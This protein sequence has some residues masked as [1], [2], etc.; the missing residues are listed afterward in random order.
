MRKILAA[1]VIASFAVAGLGVAPA[2]SA[3]KITITASPS[4][5]KF[6]TVGSKVVAAPAKISPKPSKFTLEWLYN[7]KPIAKATA[8]SYKIPA[9]Q[10]TGTLQLRE[11]AIVGTAKKVLVSNT[12]KIGELF[13]VANPQISYTDGTNT[14]LAITAAQVLPAPESIKYTFARDTETLYNPDNA[15]THTL[16]LADAGTQIAASAKIKAPAGYADIVLKSPALSIASTQRVYSQVWSDEFN[17]APAATANAANWSGEDGDGV[18]Y[19]NRGWGNSEREWYNF[20]NSTTD[21]N[22]ILNLTATSVNAANTHCY[23]GPCEFLSSKLVTKGKVGFTYGRLEARI[24]AAPGQGTWN[25]FWTL[26]TD[27]DTVYWPMCG[28]IDAMEILG[29]T[30]NHL[31]GYLHGPISNGLGRGNTKDFN[32]AL[33]DDFH[34]YTID[35]LPDQVT[36]YVDG[37]KY[38]SVSKTDRDWVFNHE[39]YAILNLAMGGNLGGTIDPALTS[40]T[41]QVDYVR[42]STINGVGTLHLYPQG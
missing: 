42:Y 15:M 38:G 9:N 24:K 31:L 36:W 34:T 6:A 35:W 19:G 16:S 10:P 23:Y 12:I 29:S 39:F 3:V 17:G 8:T 30:P 22:G 20:A 25:A 40:T 26:G 7:G 21:G 32:S 1:V 28:E 18:A 5:D 14:S 13:V 37:E 33:T 2:S 41:M 4:I 11:T 27:I